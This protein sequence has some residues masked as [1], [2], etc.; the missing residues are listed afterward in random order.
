MENVSTY[1]CFSFGFTTEDAPQET[2]K[3]HYNLGL[4]LALPRCLFSH[5]LNFVERL[6]DEVGDHL[7]SV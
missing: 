1:T 2:L 3:S 4:S 7:T 5:H 6:L